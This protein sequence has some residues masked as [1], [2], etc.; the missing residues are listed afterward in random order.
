VWKSALN[1][2]SISTTD[3]FFEIGGHSLLSIEVIATI[4]KRT[5]VALNPR[6]FVYQT[7]GQLAAVLEKRMVA[8]P[9][10]P[11]SQGGFGLL[12]RLKQKW[13]SGN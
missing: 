3:N 5:G 1:I 2:D 6:E 9:P 4:E 11:S 7:M 13:T 10:E 12:K 8:A